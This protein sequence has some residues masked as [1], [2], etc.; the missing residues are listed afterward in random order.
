MTNQ[1]PQYQQS[2]LDTVV[3]LYNQL[4]DVSNP[5]Q[6]VLTMIQN[7]PQSQQVM[8]L[9]NSGMSPRTVAL[10]MAQNNGLDLNALINNP[11]FK[12]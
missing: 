7:S 6:A 3:G 12:K 1:T 4:K 2:Q 10:Q 9:L 8:Q 11:A 5:K